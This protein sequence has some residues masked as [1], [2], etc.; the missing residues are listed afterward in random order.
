MALAR[1]GPGGG[2]RPLQPLPLLLEMIRVDRV[3]L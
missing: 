1:L 3:D 2:D